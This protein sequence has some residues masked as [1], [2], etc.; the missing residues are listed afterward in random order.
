MVCRKRGR[1]GMDHVLL[2]GRKTRAE[3]DLGKV[4]EYDVISYQVKKNLVEHTKV[5]LNGLKFNRSQKN[6]LL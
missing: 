6:T 5:R 1:L 3:N 2:Q 4:I